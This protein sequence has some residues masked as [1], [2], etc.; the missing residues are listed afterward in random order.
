MTNHAIVNSCTVHTVSVYGGDQERGENGGVQ[1]RG[2]NGGDQESGKNGGDQ[3]RGENGGDQE[4]GENGGDQERG[5]NGGDQESGENGGDQ[6]R[7]ENGGD[8]ESGENG[9]DQE[10]GENGGDQE[11]G[12]NGGDQERGEN[13]GDQES[14]ENGGDQERGENGGDEERGDNGHQ[15]SSKRK[16]HSLAYHRDAKR[17]K[18]KESNCHT[19]D[20]PYDVDS[21]VPKQ[22]VPQSFKSLRATDRGILEYHHKWLNDRIINVAQ[23][24]LKNQYGIPGLQ[25]V[26]LSNTLSMDVHLNKQ[27]VQ[28]LN[29]SNSHWLTISNIGCGP[30][31]VNIFDSGV[32]SSSYRLKKQIAS[33]LF[34]EENTITL[35]YMNV[36]HQVGTSDCGLFAIAFAAAL[37]EGIDPT[38]LVFRQPLMRNHLTTCIE[39]NKLEQFPLAK[40]RRAIVKPVKTECYDI[41]CTC[42]MP[43][44]ERDTIERM[45]MC[46]KCREW[47]HDT[48]V[49]VPDGY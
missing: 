15:Q 37:C 19:S 8:Q 45:I 28:I 11:R 31:E 21:H 38:S 3:E 27:F 46:F 41:Y 9:G 7:G 48:C 25:D 34:T 5:E 49:K 2:E 14:G 12:E 26:T 42:R 30:G 18:T 43:Y 24:M 47:Y 36:Q 17:R 33:I 35:R 23:K 22:D 40:Q 29:K 10:R 20:E 6:E 32:K 44:E 16:H 39:K 1:Q 13:G 4:R